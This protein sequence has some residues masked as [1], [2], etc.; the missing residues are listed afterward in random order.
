M[1]IEINA[2]GAFVKAIGAKDIDAVFDL[3]RKVLNERAKDPKPD[4]SAFGFMGERADSPRRPQVAD[5]RYGEA[6]SV[7][8]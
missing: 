6:P 1:D 3:W 5:L 7:N 8:G 2:G 4:G